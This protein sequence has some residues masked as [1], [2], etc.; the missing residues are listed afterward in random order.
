MTARKKTKA[1]PWDLTALVNAV[2]PKASLAERHLWWVRLTEWLRHAPVTAPSSELRTPLPL[3][4]LRHLLNVL[5]GHPGL[6][7]RVRATVARCWQ[8]VDAPALFADFGLGARQ[9]LF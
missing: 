4:R 9:S 6:Q 8:E 3:V 1:S 2:D 7:Q 5:D